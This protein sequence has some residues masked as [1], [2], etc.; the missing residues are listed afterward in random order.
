MVAERSGPAVA[1]PIAVC[2]RGA[3]HRRNVRAGPPA[4]QGRGGGACGRGSTARQRP[5][6]VMRVEQVMR[7]GDN[8]RCQGSGMGAGR[9]VI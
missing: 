2:K 6:I 3:A 7:S 4:A 1:G 5:R 8:R 9:A